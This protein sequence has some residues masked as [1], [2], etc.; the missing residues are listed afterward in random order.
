MDVAAGA[1]KGKHLR[2][3][4]IDIPEHL[5]SDFI[6]KDPRVLHNYAQRVGKRMEFIRNFGN[7]S[8]EEILDE[9]EVDMKAAGFSDKKIQ[10]LRQDFLFDY[11]RV[12]GEYVKA[13]I[14]SMHRLAGRSKRLQACHI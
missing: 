9:M 8:I 6:I 12:M 5:I 11:E 3:R 2:H 7:R 1:P 10:G 13:L 14:A 4:M